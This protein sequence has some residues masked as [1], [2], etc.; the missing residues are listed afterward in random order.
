M[1]I[2]PTHGGHPNERRMKDG[3]D[4]A[5]G[6]GGRIDLNHASKEDLMNCGLDRESAEKLLHFRDSH[7]GFETWGDFDEIPLSTEML[8]RLRPHVQL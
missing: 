7:G 2:P 4:Q 8:D 1:A 5:H 3:T 6:R